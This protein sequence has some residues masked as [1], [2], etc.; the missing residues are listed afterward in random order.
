MHNANNGENL[1]LLQFDVGSV[2]NHLEWRYL[3]LLYLINFEDYASSCI[4]YHMA[5]MFSM[6]DKVYLQN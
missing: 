4:C 1:R 2:E 3:N 6:C 5:T